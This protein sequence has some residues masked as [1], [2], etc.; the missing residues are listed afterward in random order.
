LYAAVDRDDRD[1]GRCLAVLQD[2]GY[3]LVIP[4]LALAEATYLVGAR[5]G[6]VVE[7]RFLETLSGFDIRLP[8]ASDWKYIAALVKKYGDFPLG[9]ADA[10][11]V[12]LAERLRAN[13][14]VTLDRRHFAAVRDRA[15]KPFELLPS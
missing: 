8:E 10:S 7:A 2:P 9:G 6:P 14:I 13:V 12:A 11:V 3:R 15:G 5:L 1:H 4:A